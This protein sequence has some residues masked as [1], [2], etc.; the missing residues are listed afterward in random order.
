MSTKVRD[1]ETLS[2]RN[3]S[4]SLYPFFSFFLTPPTIAGRSELIDITGQSHT[5]NLQKSYPLVV[6]GI[7]HLYQRSNPRLNIK[8]WFG[9]A[10]GEH[11]TFGFHGS[12]GFRLVSLFLLTLLDS[13]LRVG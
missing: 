6:A 11:E 4:L 12:R 10:L 7:L 5:K 1:F 13:G 3:H 2:D 9:E 8:L